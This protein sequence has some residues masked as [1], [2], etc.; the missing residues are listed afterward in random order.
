MAEGPEQQRRVRREPPP[1]ED[2]PEI[3]RRL[4]SERDELNPDPTSTDDEME[5]LRQDIARTRAEMSESVYALQE[6]MNPQYIRQQA[7]SQLRQG[8]SDRAKGASSG[9]TDTI[10]NNPIP[11]ALT[12]AGL[13]GLGWLIASGA[14]GSSESSSEQSGYRDSSDYGYGE[15]GYGE[16]GSYRQEDPYYDP[17]D[18]PEYTYSSGFTSREAG[19][20]EV[21]VYSD[22]DDD[23]S[24]SRTGQARER[25]G[26]AGQQAR[27]RA[28]Q[29]GQ[30]ARERAG[31]ASQQARQ[32]ASQAR[33]EA[34]QR[35]QQAK[36]GFQRALQESPLSLGAI[37]LGIGAA[38][39]FA[40][41][42]S[43]K[44]NELMGETRDQLAN[45]AQ[46]Q[47]DETA[48]RAQRVAKQARETA[49]EEA[50]RQDL[51]E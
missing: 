26:Q 25:A 30:Q 37:A 13:V 9:V 15:R 41:P 46:R 7:T 48:Q 2:R 36:G 43:S 14:S 19:G 24:G 27:E 3:R 28:G 10:R 20:R 40:I 32:R 51:S 18:T 47:A 33:G 16:R 35:A 39:G 34:Q 4:S 49:E 23:D 22:D 45:Q 38:V 12:G 1:G 17:Y 31:Q 42:E 29:A 8:A 11:A 6:R 44:E 50:S 5:A 21:D